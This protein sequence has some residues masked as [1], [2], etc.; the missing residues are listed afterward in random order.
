MRS[1]RLAVMRLFGD[2]RRMASPRK[3]RRSSPPSSK[4]K[5]S[6]LRTHT[7]L[8]NPGTAAAALVDP[9]KAKRWREALARFEKSSVAEAEHLDD[10]FEAIDEIRTEQLYLQGGFRTEAAFFAKHLPGLAIRTI[11]DHCV[12]ARYFTPEHLRA[13][14]VTHLAYLGRV[15][16]KKNG[17]KRLPR[18]VRIDP[19]TT[20][21][22]VPVGRGKHESLLFPA[23]TTQKLRAA[24]RGADDT[25]SK[26]A[27]IVL[28]T[29]AVVVREGSHAA[30]SGSESHVTLSRVEAALLPDVCRAIAADAKVR[31]AAAKGSK[32]PKKESKK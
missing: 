22:R 30:V 25:G 20:R 4:K 23:M 24:L 15:L 1:S 13:H 8:I 3:P 28:A 21:V 5:P 19:A 12:A 2:A 31:A 18:D 32:A 11:D 9:A 10:R 17:G 6:T 16:E 14:G 29:R 27:S 7:L 26:A